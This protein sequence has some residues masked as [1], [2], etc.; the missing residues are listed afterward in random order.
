LA[1]SLATALVED[2]KPDLLPQTGSLAWDPSSSAWEGKYGF[3]HARSPWIAQFQNYKA[4][5]DASRKDLADLQF[6]ANTLLTELSNYVSREGPKVAYHRLV[7][8][9]MYSNITAT[10]A[11]S[12]GAIRLV[13]ALS[14]ASFMQVCVWMTNS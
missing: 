9:L 13:P 3:S 5:G 14:A 2:C 7:Q 8:R 11:D 4:T 6:K 10:G 12:T 1:V